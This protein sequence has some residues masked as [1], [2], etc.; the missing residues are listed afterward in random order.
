MLLQISAA[1][2]YIYLI[3]DHNSKWLV[4]SKYIL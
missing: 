2:N 1:L 3:F 4:V